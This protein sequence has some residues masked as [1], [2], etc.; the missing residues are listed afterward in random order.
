M[1][2]QAWIMDHP[3]L[4]G[5]GYPDE[6][7]IS[8]I[9]E[10]FYVKYL[11]CLS[12]IYH[13]TCIYDNELAHLNSEGTMAL[14]FKKGGHITATRNPKER[15][16]KHGLNNC[17]WRPLQKCIFGKIISKEEHFSFKQ[18]D[19]V[20]SAWITGHN[21]LIKHIGSLKIVFSHKLSDSKDNYFPVYS[22][23]WSK[24]PKELLI[25][26]E[27]KVF[28]TSHVLCYRFYQKINYVTQVLPSDILCKCCGFSA[29]SL[30]SFRYSGT[31]HHASPITMLNQR[32]PDLCQNWIENQHK[33][34]Q[35][36]FSLSDEVYGYRDYF[37]EP[38]QFECFST[39]EQF[40]AHAIHRFVL[41]GKVY[42]TNLLKKLIARLHA[43]TSNVKTK[44][45]LSSSNPLGS[46]LT[47]WID[48][49][50]RAIQTQ[51]FFWQ[52]KTREDTS[53]L[54]CELV[55]WSGRSI[56]VKTSRS[57]TKIV[58]F[59]GN[60]R[61]FIVLRE[62]FDQYISI[63]DVTP[64][65]Q[66]WFKIM[67]EIFDCEVVSGMVF[68]LPFNTYNATLFKIGIDKAMHL[69]LAK[70]SLALSF[71][72]KRYSLHQ[73]YA[74]VMPAIKSGERMSPNHDL[75]Q[76]VWEGDVRR[77]YSSELANQPMPMGAPLIYTCQNGGLKRNGPH[78]NR[79]GEFKI[80]FS[81]I[82]SYQR[83]YNIVMVFSQYT[84]HGPYVAEN[85]AIDLLIVYK[86]KK[87]KK[88]CFAAFQVHHTFTHTC[89]V[90]P[91][92]LQY[93]QKK[94]YQQIK[95]H[96]DKVDQFWNNHCQ[97]VLK[98]KLEIIHFCHEFRLDSAVTY[99]DISDLP[100]PFQLLPND[101]LLSRKMSMQRLYQLIDDPAIIL[102]IIG[103]GQQTRQCNPD[104][105]A[106]YVKRNGITVMTTRAT[107]PTMFTSR[108]L[109]FLIREKGFEFSTVHHVL[110]FQSTTAFNS[111]CK[112]VLQSAQSSVSSK[113]L[114]FGLN[115]MIGLFGSFREVKST[116]R[117]FKKKNIQKSW[118]SRYHYTS[119]R[120]PDIFKVTRSS[121]L[122]RPISFM[123]V[124]HVVILSSY[125]TTIAEMINNCYSLF[126]PRACRLL[127]IKADSI[128]LGFS[129]QS[130]AESS[131][132]PAAE[133]KRKWGHL[134]PKKGKTPGKFR[135][136][137][138]TDNLPMADFS[139]VFPTVTAIEFSSGPNPRHEINRR[140]MIDSINNRRRIICFYDNDLLFTI[141]FNS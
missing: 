94:T 18:F 66:G 34:I 2:P 81:L 55:A 99:K 69:N 128:M 77:C 82:K 134:V 105:A 118:H 28:L 111:V 32:Y 12:V 133:F 106:I 22:K 50:Q 113:L 39:I 25:L 71:L 84:V 42:K 109:R 47:K 80:V 45:C 73:I 9:A 4:D 135:T 11:L 63:H 41:F 131:K 101:L 72:L 57:G 102:V 117:F 7:I 78:P 54:G 97:N 108:H 121:D 35:Y 3:W 58:S 31:N 112:Q 51:L 29:G 53:R 56:H 65:V 79:S 36:G 21:Q 137:F 70:P 49:I 89:Q 93:A 119:T 116:V 44:N 23:Q 26:I 126:Q 129:T 15:Y 110:V 27:R 85:K 141:P 123:Y 87:R 75:L 92:L 136:T 67:T 130:L 124:T 14:I 100:D 132:Y 103:E 114:K 16:P 90:C 76:F 17:F 43:M 6:S 46:T 83:K 30:C 62:L 40:M 95:N 52:D 74:T 115:S 91:P 8:D 24:S 5:D 125:R 139:M 19:C 98:C 61:R 107:T 127:R 37:T 48:A 60:F 20:V 59:S 10:Q 64:T 33:L 13:G 38:S 122:T 96:S 1:M 86:K 104:D 68:N 140:E 120:V 88:I 138:T